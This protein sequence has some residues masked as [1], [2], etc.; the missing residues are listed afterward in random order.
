[1]TTAESCDQINA[2]GTGLSFDRDLSVVAVGCEEK[3]CPDCRV[4]PGG[5]HH[6][7][8]DVER[9]SHCGGQWIGCG[10]DE[11]DNRRARWTGLWP[12]IAECRTMGLYCRDFHADGSPVTV[13]NPID[14]DTEH[15]TIR[16]HVPCR[17]EDPGAHEDLN[18]Y[19]VLSRKPKP[20]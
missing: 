4:L 15:G 11:H 13:E 2:S 8:C 19:A 17:A 3:R 12:G 5:T 1:M 7:G 9:C 14:W 20:T 18:R 16:F 6:G 10:H